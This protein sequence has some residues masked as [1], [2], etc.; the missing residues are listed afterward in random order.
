M[1]IGKEPLKR[2]AFGRAAAFLVAILLVNRIPEP[3]GKSAQLQ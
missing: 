1:G 3:P 2:G